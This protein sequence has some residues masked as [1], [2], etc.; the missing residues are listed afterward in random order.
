[1][2]KNCYGA[3]RRER[4]EKRQFTENEIILDT[5]EVWSVYWFSGFYVEIAYTLRLTAF[6]LGPSSRYDV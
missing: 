5:D 2:D 1:M 4:E 3:D 6:K